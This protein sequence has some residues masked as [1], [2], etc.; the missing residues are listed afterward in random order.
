MNLIERITEE[1]RHL[2]LQAQSEALDF[3]VFLRGRYQ[4][5]AAPEKE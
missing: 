1:S 3:I 2:P 4:R 5:Q